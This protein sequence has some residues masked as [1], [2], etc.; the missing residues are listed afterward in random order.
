MNIDFAYESVFKLKVVFN[1]E[2]S[3]DFTSRGPAAP[4]NAAKRQSSDMR[5]EYRY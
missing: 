2:D 4:M 5:D 3:W 1:G